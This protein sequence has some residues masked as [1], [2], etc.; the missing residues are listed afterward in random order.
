MSDVVRV[1]PR[2]IKDVI[3][4]CCQ[5]RNVD[6]GVANEIGAAVMEAHV[7]GARALTQFVAALEA[8]AVDETFQVTPV[9][10]EVDTPNPYRDGVEVDAATWAELHRVAE[11]FL[12]SAELL[13]GFD[14]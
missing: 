9:V 11:A 7:A 8:D 4:R 3:R 14:Q 6:A 1:A 12:V 13:D 5:V 10:D 2:E